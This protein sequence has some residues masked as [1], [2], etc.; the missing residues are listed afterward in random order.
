METLHIE[1]LLDTAQK[2]IKGTKASAPNFGVHS[3]IPTHLHYD[4]RRIIAEWERNKNITYKDLR[5]LQHINVSTTEYL[6]THV[7]ILDKWIEYKPSF[8][9][10]NY[11]LKKGTNPRKING[12]PN[13]R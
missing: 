13:I 5:Y 3:T 11:N 12:Y 4:V 7:Y 1:S 8:K 6:M 10:K 2:L 9:F